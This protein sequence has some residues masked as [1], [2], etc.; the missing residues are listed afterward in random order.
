MT[1]TV[2]TGDGP[3]RSKWISSKGAVAI[4]EDDEKRRRWLFLANRGCREGYQH[5]Q[6]GKEADAEIKHWRQLWWRD[7]LGAHT[8]WRKRETV[9]FPCWQG[10][11]REVP[12]RSVRKGSRCW[13]KTLETTL[14][15][16]W[17]SRS[18]QTE[19]DV[20]SQRRAWG[21]AVKLWFPREKTYRPFLSC[22]RS[23]VFHV[24]R[25]LKKQDSGWNSRRT[26]LS[27]V[28]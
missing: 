18:C 4:V 2:D 1:L 3:H 16:G 21:E 17:P 13:D 11:Q 27:A 28:N 15:E 7:D 24:E 19:E 12:A 25:S 6:G 8:R 14:V 23:R 10:M 5:G 9:T 20:R 22:P 26:L